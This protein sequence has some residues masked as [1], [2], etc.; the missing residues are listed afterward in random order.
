MTVN[1]RNARASVGWVKRR[2]VPEAYDPAGT[3]Q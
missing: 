2:A 3:A 1:W